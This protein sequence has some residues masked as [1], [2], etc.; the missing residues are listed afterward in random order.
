M[1]GPA[2]NWLERAGVC[3]AL[4]KLGIIELAETDV[5]ERIATEIRMTGRGL[6]TFNYG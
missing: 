4:L 5:L 3:G 6:L 2:E 1:P